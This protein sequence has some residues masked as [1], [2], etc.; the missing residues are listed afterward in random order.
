MKRYKLN[1]LCFMLLVGVLASCAGEDELTAIEDKTTNHFAPDP[2][3]M[4]EESVLR[5]NFYDEEK[6]YL[7][8]NDTLQ[9]E[10]L[11]TSYA[12]NDAYFVETVDLGYKIGATS[13]YNQY[14][15]QYM[16]SIEEKEAA[17][18]FLQEYIMPHLGKS[19]RP[20]SWLL[21]N[22]VSS[23]DIYTYMT[24]QYKLVVGE[25]CI[26][27][28]L[29][30]ILSMSDAAK[31]SLAK[32]IFASYLGEKFAQQESALTSFY[33]PV[34]HLHDS[35]IGDLGLNNYNVM[36]WMNENGFVSPI[37]T[38][39]LDLGYYVLI[40]YSTSMCPSK[41]L[42]V[43]DYT[44]LIFT[45]TMDEIRAQYGAYPLIVERAEILNNLIVKLGYIP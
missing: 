22:Q 10:K 37:I 28:S 33:E 6:C 4:D 42:D 27:I 41:N 17:A 14:Q 2:D 39:K 44:N 15:F 45:Y 18:A 1:Y 24:T 29:N 32:E 7:L 25:R 20:F 19:L 11:S 26:A 23:Y 9:S 43:S 40:L 34:A 13:T 8:F 12:G 30:G 31:E 21:V 16:Q 5:R 3:A 36:N 38:Y 35:Y